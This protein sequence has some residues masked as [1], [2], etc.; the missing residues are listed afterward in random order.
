MRTNVICIAA[1]SL[2][3]LIVPEVAS[4]HCKD[5]RKVCE[6]VFECMHQNSTHEQRIREGVRKNDPNEIFGE[7]NG[8]DTVDHLEWR[9][10]DPRSNDRN[11]RGFGDDI[12]QQCNPGDYSLT[13]KAG[14]E[15]FDGNE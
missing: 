5:G 6:Y 9:P 7:L 14:V 13:G 8:C 2:G 4:A 1:A 12:G 15:L 11:P 10:R 3:I